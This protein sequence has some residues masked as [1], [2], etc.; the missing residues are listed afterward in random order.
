MSN[1]WLHP[2]RRLEFGR[3]QQQAFLEDLSSLVKD[4]V[5]ANQAIRL[6]QQ[7]TDG[8]FQKVANDIAYGLA[9]GQPVA[10]GMRSWFSPATVE[11][12]RA[13]ESS[14]TLPEA[15]ESAAA[16]LSGQSNAIG[17]FIN[18]ALY[19]LVVFVASLV[20]LIFVKDSV[21][22]N[23][24][25]IKPVTS[26]P[27]VGQYL[28][29]LADFLEAWWWLLLVGL[30]VLIFILYEL[31]RQLIG[32]LRHWVDRVPGLSLY[33][34]TTAARLMETLGLLLK[35]GVALNKSLQIMHQDAQPYLAWHL[36]MMEIRLSGGKEN[37]A[38]VLD[39]DLIS[40]S[41]LMRLKVVA[42]GKG[43]DHALSSLGRKAHNAAAKKVSTAGKLIGALCL[44]LGAVMAATVVFGI[45]SIGSIIAS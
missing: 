36:W 22:D 3:K 12:I 17:E 38:D 1:K 5:P 28:Y 23:F 7:T 45:Y 8:I 4:G 13:G 10:F 25:S 33:R 9:Q 26:W 40:P 39:T 34:Q 30:G 21:L 11:I 43:I 32:P 42:M 31:L 19:P 24:A 15:M 16:S 6:I 29:Y 2:W 27:D 44:T 41:D 37:V 20:M 14:G 35:N 18:A